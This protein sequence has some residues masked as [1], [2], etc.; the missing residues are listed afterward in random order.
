MTLQEWG[1]YRQYIIKEEES[2]T[3]DLDTLE[4]GRPSPS[5][6]STALPTTTL[7]LPPP[8]IANRTDL[9]LFTQAQ[10]TEVHDKV[11]ADTRAALDH[12]EKQLCLSVSPQTTT[13]PVTT[14]G[15]PGFNLEDGDRR[16]LDL[17]NSD[18]LTAKFIHRHMVTNVWM[19]GWMAKCA[20][21]YMHTYLFVC[22][23]VGR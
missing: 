22:L 2:Q 8:P 4:M 19:D 9:K 1:Q 7:D 17:H 5:S 10:A 3:T 20:C 13:A 11:L 23:S 16:E 18:G 12:L 15:S 6:P 21:S 14:S